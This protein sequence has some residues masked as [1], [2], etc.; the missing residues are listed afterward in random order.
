MVETIRNTRGSTRPEVP[1][2][3]DGSHF[4]FELIHAAGKYRTYADNAGELCAA[5]IEEYPA[6]NALEAAAARIRYAVGVQVSLQAVIDAEADLSSC[7]PSERE[8]LLGSRHVPPELDMWEADVPLILVDTY[9]WPL[10]ELR[11]PEGRPR[12]GGGPATNL[13]WLSPATEESLV[14]SLAQAGEVALSEVR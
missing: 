5:L 3:A 12:G 7:T 6:G 4:R 14:R 9:Y 11:R 1:V 10:G 2:K 13:I 8:L